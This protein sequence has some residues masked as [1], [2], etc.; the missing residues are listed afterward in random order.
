VILAHADLVPDADVARFSWAGLARFHNVSSVTEWLCGLHKLDRTQRENA[1]KQARQIR[2]CLIQAKEYYDAAAA[3]TLATKPNLLY[4]SAMSLK[5]YSSKA[6]KAAWTEQERI[7]D[8][9]V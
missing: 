3:V 7:I 6:A 1:R 8:I 5:F 2:Y 4:Y 9:M